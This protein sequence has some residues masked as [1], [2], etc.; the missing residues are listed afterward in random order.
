MEVG[1]GEGVEMGEV[2]DGEVRVLEGVDVG[3]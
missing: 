1:V 2:G 3:V